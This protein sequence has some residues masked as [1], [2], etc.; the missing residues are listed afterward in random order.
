M[1]SSPSV[2]R[3]TRSQIAQLAEQYFPGREELLWE[4]VRR[5]AERDEA[6]WRRSTQGTYRPTISMYALALGW[7]LK[8]GGARCA[9][10][11]RPLGPPLSRRSASAEV[12]ALSLGPLVPPDQGG[13]NVP[14]NVILGHADCLSVR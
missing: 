11:K 10:C 5:V 2:E 12:P 6:L 3:W 13:R 4:I 14:Q 1:P 9:I 8:R 7:Q